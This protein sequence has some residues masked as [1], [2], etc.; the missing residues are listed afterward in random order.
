VVDV[1]DSVD[2]ARHL[3]DQGLAD[4]QR[5]VIMGGSAGGYTVLQSLVRQPGFFRAGICLYGISDLFALQMETHKFEA[6]YNDRLLGPL[7]E[8]SAVYRERS[9]LFHAE[10]ITDPVLFLHGEEDTAVPINQTEAIYASLQRRGIPCEF[11]RYAGEGHGF[12]GVETIEHVYT[13]ISRFL[14]RHV[15]YR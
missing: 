4:L 6:H 1:E 8:A 10:R 14:L 9:P 7:P 3:A 15:I 5:A 12:R 11:H 13:T 2:G